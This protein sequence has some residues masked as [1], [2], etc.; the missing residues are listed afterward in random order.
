MENENTTATP[1]S[2]SFMKYF[3]NIFIFIT[4]IIFVVFICILFIKLGSN[5]FFWETPKGNNETE[6]L[7]RTKRNIEEQIKDIKKN[8]K[9]MIDLEFLEQMDNINVLEHQIEQLKKENELLKNKNKPVNNST[10]ETSYASLQ[11]PKIPSNTNNN[12]Q[13]K[14]NIPSTLKDNKI[15][16]QN[17][18]NTEEHIY[19]SIEESLKRKS[20]MIIENQP[21]DKINDE[22]NSLSVIEVENPSKETSIDDDSEI[23]KSLSLDNSATNSSSDFEDF[24]LVDK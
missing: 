13:P 14:L 3:K 10:N 11:T 2:P 4:I 23:N 15:D 8:E 24:A 6:P 21:N 12:L 22:A 7:S 5:T 20:M 16:N 1:S 9:F 18:T 17:L 19:E